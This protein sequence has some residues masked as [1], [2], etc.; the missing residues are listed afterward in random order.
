[1]E[2]FNALPPHV[3]PRG[4][5]REANGEVTV[6]GVSLSEMAERYGTPVFV[7]DED[8]FRDRCKDM[9]AAFGGAEKVHYASKAF[10]TRRIARWV[11]EEGLNLDIASLGE[12]QVALSANFPPGRITA[13]GN[14]KSE[15]FLRVL[16]SHRVGHIV[17]DS[18]TEL[19]RL[20]KIAAE[21]GVT[22]P[23]MV[24]VKPGIEAHT[25]EFI[26]TSHEDQKF[27]FSLA[28][29][30]A[31][32]AA[33]RVIESA[34][35]YLIGLHCH[36]G[37][38]VFDAQGFSLAAQRVLT[39]YSKIHSELGIDL[40]QLDLG[41]GYGIAYTEDETPLDVTSVAQDL[42]AAVDDVARTL[43]IDAPEVLVEPGRAIAGPSTVTVYS[44]GTVKDVHV[45][46]K[47]LRRYIAV[48]GGMSDNIRPALYE[49]E[50]DVRVINRNVAGDLVPSRIV[51]SHCE[52]GD[53]LIHDRELPSGIIEGD[54]IALAATGAYCFAMSS[55]Y[56]MMGRPAVVSVKAG[57]SRVMVRRETI[58][59]LLALDE[60]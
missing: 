42:L 37:S 50:Y 2:S 41:G 21:A 14:N 38:Q 4:A 12:F 29:G 39:L 24:R 34:S 35:L 10:L 1:M 28:S 20:E 30:S 31:Y 60:G 26:A 54:L 44:V 36:V 7:V 3:W 5:R 55:R 33:K 22:Q 49:A 59:D 58:E 6:A 11:E 13:H 17:I 40:E 16:V 23:V 47:Q 45:T 15:E 8:D 19:E 53:I 9:A 52:A 27:G 18:M 51:G 25:H 56:N 57:Q 46:D 43:D 48:D 32:A